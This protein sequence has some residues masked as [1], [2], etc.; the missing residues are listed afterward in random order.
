MQDDSIHWN[1]EPVAVVVAE[2]QEQADHA[3]GAGVGELCGNDEKM[4][5]A[6]TDFAVR[7][8]ASA[9]SA[10]VIGEPSVVETGDAEKALAAAQHR[11]DRTYTTPL[12]NHNAIELH[13]A[14]VAVGRRSS[15]CT[16]PRR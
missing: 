15:S 11:V 2:T 16:T 13:A 4:R 10:Q 1:G 6:V 5:P 14:T 9:R 7:A 3:A 8:D 12:L